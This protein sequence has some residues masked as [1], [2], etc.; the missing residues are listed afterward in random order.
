[1]KTALGLEKEEERLMELGVGWGVDKQDSRNKPLGRGEISLL[2]ITPRVL[3]MCG[4][5]MEAHSIKL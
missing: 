1:M 4:K 3:I 5:P 2:Y